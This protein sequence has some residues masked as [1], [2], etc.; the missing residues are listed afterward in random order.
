VPKLR[1]DNARQGFVDPAD[2]EALYA[3]LPDYLDAPTRY[4]NLTGQ[5]KRN[6]FGLLWAQVAF[7]PDGGAVIRLAPKETKNDGGQ[8]LAFA[9]SSPVAQLL[10]AQHA[11]RRLDCAHVFHHNGRPIRDF[12]AA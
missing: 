12:Y 10:A 7:D 6:V 1:V 2:A 4:A 8:V 9:P 11:R 5:R 3:V